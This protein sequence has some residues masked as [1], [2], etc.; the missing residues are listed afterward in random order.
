MKTSAKNNTAPAQLNALAA[1]V[2]SN[3][4]YYSTCVIE[5]GV[6]FAPT[7]NPSAAGVVQ[8]YQ[9]KIGT[10]GD[11]GNSFFC[12]SVISS[13]TYGY[14]HVP[15]GKYVTQLYSTSTLTSTISFTDAG[16]GVSNYRAFIT[17]GTSP[18][19]GT[20]YLGTKFFFS[21]RF[22]ATSAKVYEP[23]PW[24]Q[25]YVQACSTFYGYPRSVS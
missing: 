18:Y 25:N 19:H 8:S 11:G 13:T 17:A 4:L 23:N 14:S 16:S 3:D 1:W 20:D 22:V 24:S 10:A 9:Y 5:N 15:Y 21:T 7:V 6:D 2:N 12:P